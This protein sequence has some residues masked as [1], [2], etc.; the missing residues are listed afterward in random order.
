MDTKVERKSPSDGMPGACRSY[1][2]HGTGMAGEFRGVRLDTLGGDRLRA[3]Q[4]DR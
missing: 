4:G 2:Q 1:L 3:F